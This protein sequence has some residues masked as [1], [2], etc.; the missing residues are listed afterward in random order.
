MEYPRFAPRYPWSERA[1]W[2]RAWV[3]DSCDGVPDCDSAL[4]RAS[5]YWRAGRVQKCADRC[6]AAAGYDPKARYWAARTLAAK[7]LFRLGYRERLSV[8]RMLPW[9]LCCWWVTLVDRLVGK[10]AYRWNARRYAE[11]GGAGALAKA[12]AEARG[13]VLEMRLSGRE[14]FSDRR[15]CGDLTAE[16]VTSICDRAVVELDAAPTIR[17]MAKVRH[18]FYEDIFC[19][20][21]R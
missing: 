19:F 2:A 15:P 7:R 10:Y 18:S 4:E 12:L 17:E 6:R 20:V 3:S 5:L 14:G 21:D 9:A 11:V 13:F 1:D 16:Q 8:W